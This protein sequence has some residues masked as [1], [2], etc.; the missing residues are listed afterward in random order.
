MQG[1][2]VSQV[3][4]F[5]VLACDVLSCTVT[6]CYMTGCML[7][8]T[9]KLVCSAMGCNVSSYTVL[10]C[11]LMQS[12]MRMCSC[13]TCNLK[14]CNRWVFGMLGCTEKYVCTLTLVRGSCTSSLQW[15]QICVPLC[16]QPR[17]RDMRNPTEQFNPTEQQYPFL[18]VLCVLSLLASY[19]FKSQREKLPLLLTLQNT[20]TSQILSFI[21]LCPNPLLLSC[22]VHFLLLAVNFHQPQLILCSCTVGLLLV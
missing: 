14:E 2:R 5:P 19:P 7:T 12:C 21:S 11:T 20:S 17:T 6:L 22:V 3:L 13:W 16:C 8:P 18:C 4:V 15:L 1:R 9:C 10:G